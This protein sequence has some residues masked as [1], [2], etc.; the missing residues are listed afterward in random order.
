MYNVTYVFAEVG[1]KSVT[2]LHNNKTT[3]V[4]VARSTS[5]GFMKLNES[6]NGA[7]NYECE[8]KC[9]LDSQPTATFHLLRESERLIIII[10]EFEFELD[11]RKRTFQRFL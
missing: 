2:N 6:M 8:N 5:T 1:R 10:W 3:V 11:R 4:V 7:E 9:R